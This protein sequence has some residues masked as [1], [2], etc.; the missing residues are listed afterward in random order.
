L[1]SPDPVV[2]A[3][4]TLSGEVDDTLEESGHDRLHRFDFAGLS[5]LEF[6]AE[7]VRVVDGAPAAKSY[8]GLHTAIYAF[9]NAGLDG[10]EALHRMG[11]W[12][13]F[14]LA[15]APDGWIAFSAE[16]RSLARG[17]RDDGL[18]DNVFFMRK[19][20]GVRVRFQGTASSR[21]P[22]L[23]VIHGG[24]DRMQRTGIVTEIQPGIYEPESH[25]FGG[26]TSM[27]YAHSLFTVDSLFWLDY[28]VSEDIRDGSTRPWTVSLKLL[29]SLF[30][31]LGIVDFED[32]GVWQR[33]RH[34]WGRAF[35]PALL[36]SDVFGEAAAGLRSM[37]GKSTNFDDLLPRAHPL[38]SRACT[39]M[40]RLGAAWLK[41]YFSTGTAFAGPREVA[42]AFTV[43]HWNRAGL[44]LTEQATITESLL[45]RHGY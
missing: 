31:A 34:H 5:L 3:L 25:L 2:P 17:L 43:F 30:T 32:I 35:P 28:F 16:L 37:W 33:I 41:D 7:C 14:G 27:R 29:R 21:E 36:N 1:L 23:D 44:T 24:I 13:Q 40:D 10:L 4:N 8:A 19:P 45:G 6:L 15:I 39:E 9:L 18:A 38:V 42:A 11:G 22:L 20:P 26:P 12:T